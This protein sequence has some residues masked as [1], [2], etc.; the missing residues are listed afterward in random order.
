M[1]LIVLNHFLSNLQL[2]LAEA[3]QDSPSQLGLRKLSHALRE[4]PQN[5]LPERLFPLKN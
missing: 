1:Q 2:A 5:P 3:V 4:H